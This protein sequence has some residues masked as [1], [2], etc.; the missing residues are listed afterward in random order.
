MDASVGFDP[1]LRDLD[2]GLQKQRTRANHP[3]Y[4]FRG[5]PLKGII[6]GLQNSLTVC[7]V[8]QQF[9]NEENA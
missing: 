7:R 3:R 8:M 4:R 1:N 5:T 6:F 2:L 9:F